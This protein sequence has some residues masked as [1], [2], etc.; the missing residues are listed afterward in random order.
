MLQNRRG[1]GVRLVKLNAAA[2]GLSAIGK[3]VRRFQNRLSVHIEKRGNVNELSLIQ[4]EHGDSSYD[5]AC[6][7]CNEVLDQELR[8]RVVREMAGIRPLFAAQATLAKCA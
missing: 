8:E 4:A 2:Y 7:F 6:E 3:A 5:L 1:N